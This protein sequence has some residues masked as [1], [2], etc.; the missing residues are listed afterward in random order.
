MQ[1]IN[2]KDKSKSENRFENSIA[3]LVF[4][5]KATKCFYQARLYKTLGE[6]EK[7]LRM[8][9]VSIWYHEQARKMG[10]ASDAFL[11]DF[12]ELLLLAEKGNASFVREA[13]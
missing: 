7:C 13:A 11:N 6:T 12:S 1:F 8:C 10:Y 5:V 2:Q 4:R 3:K 9:S